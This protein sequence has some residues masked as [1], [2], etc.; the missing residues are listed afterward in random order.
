MWCVVCGMWH[1]VCGMWHVVSFYWG[2]VYGEKRINQCDARE[3]RGAS[4]GMSMSGINIER[5]YVVCAYV[6]CVMCYVL[7]VMFDV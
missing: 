7:C 5:W 2:D 3:E 6:L 1:V 4:I